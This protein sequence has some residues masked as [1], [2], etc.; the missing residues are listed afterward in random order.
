MA[1]VAPDEKVRRCCRRE[2]TRS[3]E[4]RPVADVHVRER[5]Q[6]AKEVRRVL[7]VG[8]DCVSALPRRRDPSL[9]EALERPVPGQRKDGDGL[10]GHQRQIPPGRIMASRAP[11]ATEWVCRI[12]SLLA[13]ISR[14]HRH[15]A[16]HRPGPAAS[17]PAQVG[18]SSDPRG[19]PRRVGHR[20][21]RDS[22]RV[23]R[24]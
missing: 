16:Q 13:W 8:K 3:A 7:R 10:G 22:T 5:A 1:D 6:P 19:N 24:R 20:R 2:A 12:G 14:D 21:Y 18:P 23:Q 11:T 17:P 4:R 15:A 9:C